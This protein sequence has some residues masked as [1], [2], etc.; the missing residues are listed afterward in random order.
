MPFRIQRT[1]RGLPNLL[2]LFGGNTPIELEDRIRGTLDLTQAYGAPVRTLLQGA[3][4]ALTEGTAIGLGPPFSDQ[5]AACQF[6]LLYG[7]SLSITQT[8]TL[9][10]LSM[11]LWLA[12]QPSGYAVASQEFTQ[13]GATVTGAKKLSWY[14]PYPILL[15]SRFNPFGTVDI[16][17]TDANV[18]AGFSIDV[19]LLS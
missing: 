16:I 13:F 6:Y 10:A 9:T 17:G 18:A 2:G 11:S 14:A 8:A 15:P 1:P 4:G 19:A 12:I 3:S 5:L 7:M